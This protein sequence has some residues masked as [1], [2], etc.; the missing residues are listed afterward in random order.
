MYVCGLI[1]YDKIADNPF[2]GLDRHNPNYASHLVVL[3]GFSIIKFVVTPD[4]IL[5]YAIA[6]HG[7]V[8]YR[9][10][11]IYEPLPVVFGIPLVQEP[12]GYVHYH[13]L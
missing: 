5:Q 3:Y 9:R 10:Y 8:K 11:L 7:V 12:A 13:T 6:L 1:T 2:H 4:S